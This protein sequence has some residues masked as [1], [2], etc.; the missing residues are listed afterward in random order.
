MICLET[1]RLSLR[2]FDESDFEAVHAYASDPEVTR[3]TGF[4]PNTEAE[5]RGFIASV[6]RA[7]LDPDSRHLDLAIVPRDVGHVVGACGIRL[8]R[9]DVREYEIG[10]VLS[11]NHWRRGIGSEA[12]RRLRDFAFDE[13]SA[14]R[15]YARVIVGNAPSIAL[16]EKLG[17]LLEGTRR[18]DLF[19]RGAWHDTVMY[20]QVEGD[21]R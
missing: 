3:F 1:E 12:V 18:A 20:A 4:G 16:I 7:A 9:E 6:R 19:A 15:L 2:P 13:W 5:T 8:D 21:P 14:H 11:R 10:Y 17:F